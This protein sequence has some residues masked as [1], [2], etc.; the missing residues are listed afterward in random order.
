MANRKIY[1]LVH[2]RVSNARFSNR[3]LRFP[4][5][6]HGLVCLIGYFEI[7]SYL[8]KPKDCN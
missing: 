2:D 4:Q 6:K 7:G 5:G 3:K 8:V 1:L